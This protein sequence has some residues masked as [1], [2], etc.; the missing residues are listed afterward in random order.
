MTFFNYLCALFIPPLYFMMC[1]KW[2]SFIINAVFYGFACLMAVSIIGLAVAPFFWLV[3]AGHALFDL[4]KQLV[5]EHAEAIAT[6]MAE[7]VE[8][9]AK[10]NEP[11]S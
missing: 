11:K 2:G 1:G 5:N 7:K 3:A 8:I 9:R 6:K 10:T 4:R